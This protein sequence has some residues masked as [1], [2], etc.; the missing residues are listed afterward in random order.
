MNYSDLFSLVNSYV[1]LTT[2]DKFS[3]I[4]TQL[5]KEVLKCGTIESYRS[6]NRWGKQDISINYLGNIKKEVISHTILKVKCNQGYYV[7]DLTHPSL[8]I[9]EEI[10]RKELHKLNGISDIYAKRGYP[11]GPEIEKLREKKL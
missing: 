2:V 9:A 5:I 8:V 3:F 6:I 1:K 10:Y 4:N 11:T 7:V